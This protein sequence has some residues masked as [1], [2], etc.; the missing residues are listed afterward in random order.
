MIN[1]L[2]TEV[3]I[4]NLY[5]FQ[6]QT[7]LAYWYL[8][9][10]DWDKAVMLSKGWK[11]FVGKVDDLVWRWV[12]VLPKLDTTKK[13]TSTRVFHQSHDTGKVEQWI[14]QYCWSPVKLIDSKEV[15]GTSYGNMYKCTWCDACVGCHKGTVK[16]LG[17]L[18]NTELRYWRNR[19]HE[20]FDKLWNGRSNTSRPKKYAWL[21]RVMGKIPDDTHIALFEVEDCKRCIEL[22]DNFYN[23]VLC[24]KPSTTTP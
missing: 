15:Y 7:T 18:A 13:I 5:R 12:K 22:S 2:W 3:T 4:G 8:K 24:Q 21:S 1:K 14:C 16:P 23:T 9:E 10:V 20:S 19:A 6:W 11:F 17:T